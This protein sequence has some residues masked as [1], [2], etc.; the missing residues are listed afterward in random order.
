MLFSFEYFYPTL[1]LIYINLMMLR[2]TILSAVLVFFSMISY[3]QENS[4]PNSQYPGIWLGTMN[5][6]EDM[7]LQLAFE[8]SNFEDLGFSAKMNVIEQKA[9]DILMDTCY[10]HKDSIHIYFAAA[11]ISYIGKYNFEEDKIIGT[12]GQGGGSFQLNLSRVD[13]LHTE[14]ERPQTPR[15]PFPYKEEQITFINESANVTLAGTLTLPANGE[16][17]PSVI[18]VAGSGRNDRNETPMGHFLLLSDHLTRNGFAVLRYDKRGVGESTGDYGAA[19]TFDFTD[20]VIAGIEYLRSRSDICR[21]QIGIIGHSEGALIAPI[22]A[23]DEG[24]EIS[25]IVMMGGIGVKGSDLLIK[26]TEKILKVNGA[27]ETEISETVKK[28]RMYYQLAMEDTDSETLKAK[29]I[30]YDSEMDEGLIG[31]LQWQWFR[32]M[33][34]INPESYLRRIECPSLA[35]TGENDLQC[36][37]EQ[38]LPAIENALMNGNCKNYTVKSM[39]GL[40]HLFQTSKSGS[41]YEYETIPEIIAPQVLDY[42]VEWLDG[43]Q[44]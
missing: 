44:R 43:L 36:V 9:F 5:V 4:S 2:N 20:D 8:I 23:S 33:L 35:I 30:A 1:Q 7:N 16:C 12:Y 17:F 3:G 15:K 28:N 13:S 6:T 37:A 24:N 38:N 18:L 19:T 25:F 26:Q 10:V 11:G 22:V 14:V 32:T 29:L 39:P 34:S 40:N 42:I 41:P 21:D 27:S 31:M